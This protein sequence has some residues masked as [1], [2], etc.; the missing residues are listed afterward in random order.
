[1]TLSTFIY[2]TAKTKRK[3]WPLLGSS[4]VSGLGSALDW[5]SIDIGY[6]ESEPHNSTPQKLEFQNLNQNSKL[7]PNLAQTRKLNPNYNFGE[8]K[9][10]FLKTEGRKPCSSSIKFTIKGEKA[11]AKLNKN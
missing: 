7:S 2:T 5:R 3:N 10:R 1:M 6:I 11:E 8:K 9:K 4:F